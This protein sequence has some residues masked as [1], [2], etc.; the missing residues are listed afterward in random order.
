MKIYNMNEKDNKVYLITYYNVYYEAKFIK[1]IEIH[2]GLKNNNSSITVYTYRTR[3][4]DIHLYN[5]QKSGNHFSY[6]TTS[7][8]DAV[9][10]IGKR[11]YKGKTV[12][13]LPYTEN[14]ILKWCIQH[15]PE[16]LL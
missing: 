8:E 14:N 7:K 15:H 4:G 16:K 3:D 6:I 12:R 5:N 2:I 11:L 1:S 13:R 10:E 9:L